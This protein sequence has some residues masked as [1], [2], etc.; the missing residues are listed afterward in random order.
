M[1]WAR[2]LYIL[3]C[4]TTQLLPKGNYRESRSKENICCWGQ[5]PEK[6][7]DNKDQVAIY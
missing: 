5:N 7:K 2:K 4:F 3:T 6:V 1:Y